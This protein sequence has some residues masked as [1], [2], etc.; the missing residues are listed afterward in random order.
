MKSPVFS[1]LLEAN[2]SSTRET[3]FLA[4]SHVIHRFPLPYART[5]SN[6][7][8]L[9]S[10]FSTATCTSTTRSS[11]LPSWQIWWVD[12]PNFTHSL[13][14]K[15]HHLLPSWKISSSSRRPTQKRHCGSQ[16]SLSRRF[17]FG[18]D[19][20]QMMANMPM[21]KIQVHTLV[22]PSRGTLYLIIS[23]SIR[24]HSWSRTTR[25]SRSRSHR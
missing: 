25:I 10:S 11:L 13:V 12:V 6:S 5:I 20:I 1:S 22:S 23:P 17:L 2:G 18:V 3:F 15:S 9:T 19:G 8:L 21:M 14:F 4:P 7:H 24:Y 16:L